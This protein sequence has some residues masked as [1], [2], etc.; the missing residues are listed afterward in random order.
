M[1]D[2]AAQQAYLTGFDPIPSFCRARFADNGDL[3]VERE[4]FDSVKLNLPYRVDERGEPLVATG[5]LAQRE[6]P[7]LL[8][9]E[10]ARGKLNVVRNQ[11]A[12]WEAAGFEASAELKS[13]V[14]SAT[15]HLTDAAVRQQEPLVAALFAHDALADAL[16]AAELAAKV[17]SDQALAVRHR[18]VARLPIAFGCGLGANRWIPGL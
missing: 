15:H 13:L 3:L 6:R 11:I 1:S 18:T 14:H 4:G 10:L 16:A 12:D 7:Y 2:R 9:L 5:T 17:Y 8:P